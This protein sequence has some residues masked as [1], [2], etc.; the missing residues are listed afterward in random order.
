MC[1]V[2]ASLAIAP[3]SALTTRGRHRVNYG[4]DFGNNQSNAVA[5]ALQQA[6]ANVSAAGGNSMR[7]WLFVEGASIP[8]FDDSGV[9]VSLDKSGTLAEDLRKYIRYAA[10]Q[11][12]FVNLCLW[13][14]AVLRQE[15]TIKMIQ[16]KSGDLVQALLDHAITPLA[17]ALKGEPGLGAWE[18]MNELEGSLTLTKDPSEACFDTEPIL[19]NT[20]AG[21]AG[22]SY[23]MQQALRFISMQAAAIKAADPASIITSGAW[24]EHSVTSAF[25]PYNGQGFRNFYSDECMSKVGTGSLDFYQVHAYPTAAPG[26]AALNKSAPHSP[27]AQAAAA[28]KLDKPLVIGEFGAAKAGVQSAAMYAYGYAHG[29]S[30]AWDWALLGGD[31]TRAAILAG[32]ATLKGQP[33]VAVTI[34]G[35]PPP[36]TCHCSDVAPS[37]DY[38]CAQQAGWG[39][40]NEPFM[41]GFCCRSCHAC[42]GCS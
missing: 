38:T 34:G 33:D 22:H 26:S 30:G 8:E 39:K 29:Y 36:D 2:A 18:I 37:Q 15:N 32:I 9:V 40:C 13:N 19:K 17:T 35:T 14:G 10:S 23:T 16:D 31:P 28:Y 3:P 27:F 12:V 1:C 25:S 11:N 6:I 5:C 21:W 4:A 24:S 7:I 20:G 41:K 42:S